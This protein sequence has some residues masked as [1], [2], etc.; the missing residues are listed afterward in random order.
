MASTRRS[1]NNTAW[2]NVNDETVHVAGSTSKEPTLYWDNG[3][4]K[5]TVGSSVQISCRIRITYHGNGTGLTR[6]H[7]A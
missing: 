3:L 6:N 7:S 1:S 4:L 5:I 2:S